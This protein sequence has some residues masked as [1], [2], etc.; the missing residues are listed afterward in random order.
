MVMYNV[1]GSQQDERDVRVLQFSQLFLP[2]TEKRQKA[3]EMYNRISH[4]Q[5]SIEH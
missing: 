1:L 4:M 3:M 2:D 5:E